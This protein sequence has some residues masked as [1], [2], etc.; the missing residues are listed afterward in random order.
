LRDL[1]RENRRL[2]PPVNGAAA[3]VDAALPTEPAVLPS[4]PVVDTVTEEPAPAARPS[5]PAAYEQLAQRVADLVEPAV[6]ELVTARRDKWLARIALNMIET[7]KLLDPITRIAVARCLT[8][9]A[10]TAAVGLAS[11]LGWLIYQAIMV[12]KAPWPLVGCLAVAEA[13]LLPII[14]RGQPKAPPEPSR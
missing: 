3:I 10:L 6:A 12:D 9:G 5:L 4:P 7:A 8:L 2:T 13:F 11:W 14:W 1:T